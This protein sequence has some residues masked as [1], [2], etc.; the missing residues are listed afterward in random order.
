ME[1]KL[2]IDLTQ[3]PEGKKAIVIDIVGGF[4]L[5]QRLENLGIRVGTKITKVSSQLIGGPIVV[6]VFNSTVAIGF[7]MA[8][9]IIVKLE[10]D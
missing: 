4:S 8:K 3:L 1:R 5:T 6:K 10:K 7:G 9:K 2:I